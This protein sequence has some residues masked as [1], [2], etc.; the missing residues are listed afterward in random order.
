MASSAV[1]KYS[2]TPGF[3]GGRF[4]RYDD[5]ELKESILSYFFVFSILSDSRLLR[6]TRLAVPSRA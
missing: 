3:S 6:R 4:S 2:E 5:K 1:K